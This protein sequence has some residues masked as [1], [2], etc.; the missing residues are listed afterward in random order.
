MRLCVLPVQTVEAAL[1]PYVIMTKS[2]VK[3]PW[4]RGLVSSSIQGWKGR[5]PSLPCTSGGSNLRQQ[6]SW[7]SRLVHCC[8]SSIEAV[9]II[10]SIRQTGPTGVRRLL[11]AR[12][13]RTVQ[14]INQVSVGQNTASYCSRAAVTTQRYHNVFRSPHQRG[15]GCQSRLGFEGSVRRKSDAREFKIFNIAFLTLAEVESVLHTAQ[16]SGLHSVFCILQC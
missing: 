7:R 5:R 4:R 6:P 8:R 13:S 12:R 10:Y 15:R 1:M 11:D 14:I 3:T 16:Y 2:V 9:Y